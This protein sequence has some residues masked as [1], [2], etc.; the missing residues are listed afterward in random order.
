MAA[1]ASNRNSQ[2]FCLPVFESQGFFSIYRCFFDFIIKK[3]SYLFATFKNLKFR[4]AGLLLSEFR[5]NSPLLSRRFT[6][7]SSS[8]RPAFFSDPPAAARHFAASQKSGRRL[9]PIPMGRICCCSRPNKPPINS[10]ASCWPRDPFRAIHGCTSCPSSALRFFCSINCNSRARACS[11]RRAASWC[12]AAC[13]RKN[14]INLNYSAPVPVSL[15]SAAT[16]AWPCANF[17]ITN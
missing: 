1:P 5:P 17:S 6:V 8:C 3:F 15:A 2:R 4:C 14:V 13:S 12:C 11:T 16:S 10:S 9:H 7:K